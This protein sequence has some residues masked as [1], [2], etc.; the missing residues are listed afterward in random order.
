MWADSSCK[1]DHEIVLAA[2]KRNGLALQWAA[3]PLLED[4]TFAAGQKRMYYL[5]KITL[6]S[7]RYTIVAHNNGT[8]DTAIRMCMKRLGLN[9]TGSE[10]LVHGVDVVPCDSNVSQWP[11]IRPRGEISEYQLILSG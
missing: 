3:D 6:L 8:L 9:S 10:R 7:G 11:G 4:C 5:L 2:V 1:S